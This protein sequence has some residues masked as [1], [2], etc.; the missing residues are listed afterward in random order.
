MPVHYKVMSTIARERKK[1]IQNCTTP[2]HEKVQLKR[3][4]FIIRF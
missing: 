4:E 1:K 3:P 2:K